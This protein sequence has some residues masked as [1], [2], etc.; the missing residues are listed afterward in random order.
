MLVAALAA[1]A[2]CEQQ[3][4]APEP[5]ATAEAAAA[6]A[7]PTL[8]ADGKPSHGTFRITRA[9]GTTITDEV[10]PDGTYLTTLPDGKTETGR[11]EQKDPNTYCVTEDKEGA[12]QKCYQEQVDDKG[13]Y[14]SRDPETGE[15]STVVRVSDTAGAAASGPAPWWQWK[16]GLDGRIVCAQTMQGNWTKVGGP[17]KSDCKTPY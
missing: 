14:T 2:A 8:A 17:F 16:S 15:V 3:Q 6:P 10:R 12:T 7:A 5:E 1:L 9:D 13:V 11:W 4:A